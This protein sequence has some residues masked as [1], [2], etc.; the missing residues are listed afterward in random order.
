M[1][2]IKLELPDVFGFST[3]L[4]V[5]IGDINYGGHL[6]NDALLSLM[7]EARIRFL[8]QYGFS[9]K[10]AGGSGLIMTD[11]V[12]IYKAQAFS[13]DKLIIELAVNDI[14]RKGCDFV[15]RITNKENGIEIARSKTGIVFFDYSR[16]KVVRVPEKFK[17][18]FVEGLDISRKKAHKAQREK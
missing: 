7:H 12:I 10:D 18:V 17:A 13:G 16:N 4:T 15:Y 2:R 6:G 14:S 8:A 1:A 3:E 11:A 9:E 5:R